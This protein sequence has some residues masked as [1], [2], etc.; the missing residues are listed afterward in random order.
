MFSI[1][2]YNCSG[3]FRGQNSVPNLAEKG[4]RIFILSDPSHSIKKLRNSFMAKRRCLM[5]GGRRIK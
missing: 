4:R 1:R 5:K 3:F 2:F